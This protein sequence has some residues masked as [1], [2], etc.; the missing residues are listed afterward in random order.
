LARHSGGLRYPWTFIYGLI[1]F[2]CDRAARPRFFDILRTIEVGPANKIALYAINDL[3]V[4]TIAI[5]HYLNCTLTIS[6]G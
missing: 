5:I 6:M 3:D 4:H 1:L 2:L